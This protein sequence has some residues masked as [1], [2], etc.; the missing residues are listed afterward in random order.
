MGSPLDVKT[1]PGGLSFDIYTYAMLGHPTQGLG[2]SIKK[3]LEVAALNKSGAPEQCKILLD[4][5]YITPKQYSDLWV[6]LNSNLTP[7]QINRIIEV[8]VKL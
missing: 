4:C 1:P 6:W 5:T 3:Q 2:T 8:N 7:E